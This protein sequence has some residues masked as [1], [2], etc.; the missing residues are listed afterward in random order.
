MQFGVCGDPSVAAA[1]ARASYDFAEW[2]VGPALKP[3]EPEERY[4]SSADDVRG[5][6]LPY[7]ALNCFIPGDMK[8]TGP[9]VDLAGLRKY[10]TVA[11]ERAGKLDVEIIVFGSGNARQVPEGFNARMAHEQIVSFCS[12]VGPVA[13]D[14]GVTV[15]VEPLNH[16]ECNILTTL[17]ECAALV[18]EVDHPSI[19]LLADACHLLREGDSHD[20]I[21]RHADL[22]SHVHIATNMNRLAPGAEPC[23]FTP[24]FAALAAGG[25]DGRIS[26]E[27]EI[28]DPDKA[29]PKALSVM[30]SLAGFGS[31]KDSVK[32]TSQEHRARAARS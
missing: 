6:A 20:D 4:L 21:V 12:M 31:R 9:D 30:R 15:V 2:S 25:Y 13:G 29:L 10:V 28:A 23:D 19:R 7:P 18:R 1:A 22:L 14:H 17:A 24:F 26:I 32:P 8:I 27:S 5:A 11:C 16:R 3:G